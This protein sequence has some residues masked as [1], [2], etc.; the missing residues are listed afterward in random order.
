MHRGSSTGFCGFR[1][2]LFASLFLPRTSS[3]A[4]WPAAPAAAAALRHSSLESLPPA[5]RL[6]TTCGNLKP[7]LTFLPWSGVSETTHKR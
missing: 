3:L 6:R 2:R 7:S 5:R 1:P 4:F